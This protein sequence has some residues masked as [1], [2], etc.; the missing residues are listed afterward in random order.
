MVGSS[1]MMF[2]AFLVASEVS[3]SVTKQAKADANLVGGVL[4]QETCPCHNKTDVNS[5]M[6]MAEI[7]ET[8][9]E[10]RILCGS[11]GVLLLD[12]VCLGI[13]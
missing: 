2:W 10:A 1:S 3:F 6:E 9:R 8:Q 12:W 13:W 5:V 11:R 7:P 4:A